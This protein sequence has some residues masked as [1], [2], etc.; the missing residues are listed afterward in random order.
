MSTD[1]VSSELLIQLLLAE[2]HLT[3]DVDEWVEQSQFMKL[4]T[5]TQAEIIPELADISKRMREVRKASVDL[6]LKHRCFAIAYCLS[7][8]MTRYD[9]RKGIAKE[10]AE[11][12]SIAGDEYS[13]NHILTK[14]LSGVNPI[15]PPDANG[16]SDLIRWKKLS[17]PLKGEWK[18]YPPTGESLHQDD[19][20]VIEGLIK[21]LT[22]QTTHDLTN[23]IEYWHGKKLTDDGRQK[24]L[25]VR[26][27]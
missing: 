13:A 14:W 3:N 22:E 10:I 11:M 18:A 25:S 4:I 20:K 1:K 24:K 15:A 23:R 6:Q 21:E 5:S 27:K 19:V 2:S 9:D 12:L 7:Q 16:I 26:I 8:P 17:P